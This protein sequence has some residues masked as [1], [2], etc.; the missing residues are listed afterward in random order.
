MPTKSEQLNEEFQQGLLLKENARKSLE[1]L[2]DYIQA[3]EHFKNAS[4]LSSEL[5][6]EK[7]MSADEKAQHIAFASYYSFE[8][9]SCL[10]NYSYEK[11]DIAT[12]ITNKNAALHPLTDAISFVEHLPP[13]ISRDVVEH[14]SKN[15]AN[16][17]FYHEM[18]EASIYATQ[19]RGAWDNGQL[20]DALDFYRRAAKMQQAAIKMTETLQPAYHRITLANHIGMM[21]NALNTLAQIT[22]KKGPV[23]QNDDSSRLL[24]SESAIDLL[25]YTLNA[26][27]FSKSAFEQNPE[28]DQYAVGAQVSL[29]N[30]QTFLKDNSTSWLEFYI[31]F[32]NQPEFLKI[33]KN[34]NL[35]HFKEVE[36]QRYF[37]ENKA[38]KVW[39]IRGFFL[40]VLIV[41]SGIIYLF[42]TS[43]TN[44][45]YLFL[46]F[47][48]L[49]VLFLLT[50][51]LIL[52][53]LGDLSEQGFLKLVTL[54]LQHQFRFNWRSLI[55][56]IS[57]K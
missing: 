51:G 16:W 56:K 18:E 34:T 57:P 21:S 12:A 53:S 42:A 43:F 49:E 4:E 38:L 30:I 27:L 26:Y 13:N 37:K 19:A 23:K 24:P 47:I 32:E 17:R 8:R 15:L 25:Q 29:N 10:G 50:G 52:R 6:D 45:W 11:R 41:I 7:N 28:W 5:A 9:H 31:A 14:L 36:A 39:Q 46:I 33:I 55:N 44:F 2:E 35:E 1:N 22:L 20:I 48:T 40:S 3:A 54:A